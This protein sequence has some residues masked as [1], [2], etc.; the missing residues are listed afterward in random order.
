MKTGGTSV[1]RFLQ[2][3]CK[4]TDYRFYK[5]EDGTFIYHNHLHN[6]PNLEPQ[7]KSFENIKHVISIRNPIPRYISHLNWASMPMAVQNL[8]HDVEADTNA[9][10]NS[11]RNHQY[12]W[13]NANIRDFDNFTFIRQETLEADAQVA[14]GIKDKMPFENIMKSKKVRWMNFTEDRRNEIRKYFADEYSMLKSLGIEYNI[15]CIRTF[16][17]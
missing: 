13:L 8:S 5:K 2:N 15:P 1:D 3:N 6:W 17:I 16:S 14:F 12:K 10:R 11:I 9:Y 7:F 4:T